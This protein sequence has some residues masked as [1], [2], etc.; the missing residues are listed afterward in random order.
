M[1]DLKVLLVRLL[2]IIHNILDCKILF[3]LRLMNIIP[4]LALDLED[5]IP[6]ALFSVPAT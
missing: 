6:Q 3:C 4:I 5:T 2:N 1:F